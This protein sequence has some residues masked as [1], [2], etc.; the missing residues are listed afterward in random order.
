MTYCW[1]FGIAIVL[2]LCALPASAQQ[3]AE[4]TQIGTWQGRA[5]Y[6]RAH[7]PNSAGGFGT[8]LSS[9]NGFF[10]DP[11]RLRAQDTVGFRI[12]D[13]NGSGIDGF[14][15]SIGSRTLKPGVLPGSMEDLTSAEAAA[16]VSR[17]LV[18]RNPNGEVLYQKP[19]ERPSEAEPLPPPRPVDPP[20]GGGGSDLGS[21]GAGS[22]GGIVPCIGREPCTLQQ[23]F[24]LGTRIFNWLLATGGAVAL[25]A[26]I[27]GGMKYILAVFQGADSKGINDAKQSIL[28][29]I[30]GLVILLMTYAIVNTILSVLE[31][32]T[33]GLPFQPLE[34]PEQ[35]PPP[36]PL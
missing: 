5:V 32:K 17:G 4:R 18:V 16:A 11:S 19:I 24:E 15:V 20:S 28:Y 23:L 36:R 34:V 6:L 31:L 1:K 30:I 14:S 33:E 7:V 21:G 13:P 8:N 22:S 25:L 9:Q 12:E 3:F 10:L 27:W 35:L 2:F 29:A 26:L